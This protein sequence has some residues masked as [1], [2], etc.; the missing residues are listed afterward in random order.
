[1]GYLNYVEMDENGV[2]VK[3]VSELPF[4]DRVETLLALGDLET[5]MNYFC[6]V[7]LAKIDTIGGCVAH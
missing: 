7:C 6:G 1:M 5:K 3:D 4:A 2:T